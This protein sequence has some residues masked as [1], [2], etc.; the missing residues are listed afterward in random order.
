[1]LRP[2]GSTF[3][4]VGTEREA[5]P[6]YVRLISFCCRMTVVSGIMVLHQ[7][8]GRPIVGFDIRRRLI[9]QSRSLTIWRCDGSMAVVFAYE[10]TP[11]F[12]LLHQHAEYLVSFWIFWLADYKR[13]F[14]LYFL[15]DHFSRQIFLVSFLVKK[16]KSSPENSPS[17]RWWVFRK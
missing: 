14:F 2:S 11:C 8:F 13:S 4:L 15:E 1:M 12:A 10:W 5:C 7:P 6:I 9:C 16:K 3:V 17:F